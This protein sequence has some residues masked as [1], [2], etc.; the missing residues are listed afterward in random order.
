MTASVALT[1]LFITAFAPLGDPQ[2]A[3]TQTRG[4]AALRALGIYEPVR[5]VGA[6]GSRKMI[7]VSRW[8]R[9]S[10]FGDVDEGQRHV[11]ELVHHGA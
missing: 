9:C 5:E 1:S 3:T 7:A 6:A 2:R 8:R 11:R 4:S 10:A